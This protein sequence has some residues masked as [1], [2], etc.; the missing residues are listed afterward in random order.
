[1]RESV[2]WSFIDYGHRGLCRPN[3]NGALRRS[4]IP[5]ERVDFG[6]AETPGVEVP[7]RGTAMNRESPHPH[8]SRDPPAGSAPIS[9][10]SF[11]HRVLDAIRPASGAVVMA[12]G[13][14]SIDLDSGDHQRFSQPSR[15]GSPWPSGCCWPSCW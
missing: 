10:R 1:M 5:I 3:L 6:W 4:T 7:N 9:P 8:A 13:V 2:H 15:S 11:I 12:S 14:V